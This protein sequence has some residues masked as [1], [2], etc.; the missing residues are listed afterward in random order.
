MTVWCLAEENVSSSTGSE[1]C[2]VG[3]DWP[4]VMEPVSHSTPRNA[5]IS[6]QSV[7]EGRA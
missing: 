6:V 7:Q 2:V 3:K 5:P 4:F 1:D